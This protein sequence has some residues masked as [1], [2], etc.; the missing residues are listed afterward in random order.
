MATNKSGIDQ[1]AL[2]QMFAEAGAR[3]SEALRQ[4]VSQA[5]LRALQGRELTLE[6][7]RGVLKT[8]TQAASAGAARNAGEPEQVETLL[9]TAVEGMD[10]ALLQAVEAHRRALQSFVEQGAG[11]QQGGM[12]SAIAELEKLEDTFFA[13][14]SKGA[15][16]TGTPLEGPWS[17]VLESMKANGTDTGTQASAAIQ[18]LMAQAQTALRDSRAMGLKAGQALMDSYAALV[19]GVLIGMSEGLQQGSKSSRSSRAAPAA[20]KR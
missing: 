19:S 14:V 2:I 13:A 1:D 18:Q 8:V 10:A 4:A 16:A 9:E 20:R 12:K 17:H 11:L 5:T 15:K 6:N 7:I 3:Q